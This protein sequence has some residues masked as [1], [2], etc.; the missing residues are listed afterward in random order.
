MMGTHTIKSVSLLSIFVSSVLGCALGRVES[1]RPAEWATPVQLRGVA[2]L[3]KVTGDMDSI[4]YG[5]ES[6]KM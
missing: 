6:L 2:N 5:F 4:G 1:N 3:C